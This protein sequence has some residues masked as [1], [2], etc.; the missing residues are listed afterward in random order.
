MVSRV[1]KIIQLKWRQTL[2]KYSH[3]T[4]PGHIGALAENVA[5]AYLKQQGLTFIQRNYHTSCGEIDLIMQDNE[6]IVFI[7]VRYRMGTSL[8]VPL[9]SITL[10]K[11]QK[12]TK[13][14]NLYCHIHRLE[15]C[16][17]RF[18]VV[19]IVYQ[20]NKFDFYWIKQAFN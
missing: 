7:E 15:N 17:I 2:L 19:A 5:L 3:N 4:L 14:A 20:A 10:A 13:A 18:D 16:P 9:E 12:V 8:E 1:L 6:D 11:Q